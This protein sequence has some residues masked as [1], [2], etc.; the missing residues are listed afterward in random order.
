MALDSIQ[1]FSL[2]YMV[3]CLATFGET[4]VKLVASLLCADE[5]W[6]DFLGHVETCKDR[7][8][9]TITLSYLILNCV[10]LLGVRYVNHRLCQSFAG[11]S[12]VRTLTNPYLRHKFCINSG[13]C[14]MESSFIQVPVNSR[15]KEDDSRS[16]PG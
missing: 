1:D 4:S 10:Q 11:R 2:N 3:V 12:S 16:L 14:R 7:P 15:W 8:L 6:H 9:P 5:F 13:Q